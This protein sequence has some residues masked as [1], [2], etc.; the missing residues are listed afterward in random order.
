MCLIIF[1]HQVSESCPLVVA[2]NR[3]EFHARPTAPAQFW[4]EDPGLLAGR[5]LQAGGTW[6][7]V[8]RNGRFAAITNFRDPSQTLPAARSRGELPTRFLLGA[9]GPQG[10]LAELEATAGDYAGFNLLIGQEDEL[11]Y[12]SNSGP[13]ATRQA[14]RVAPGIYGL[15]NARLDTPWPKV[16]LGKQAMARALADA[17]PD[18]DQLA[19]I[20][21]DRQLAN[22]EQL[23]ILGL[24]GD[25]DQLLSA[26]FIVNATYGTRA[27]TTC[28]RDRRGRYHWREKSVGANGE[29]IGTVLEVT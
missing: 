7:G 6:M 27:T 15:S 3:D 22:R 29:P 17:T 9:S 4:P 21:G 16:A 1:A 11:W 10:F 26:Q 12:F 5:D 18:H 8:H 24:N 23:E 13:L 19:A 2:A 28:W 25:M 14:T 20:V